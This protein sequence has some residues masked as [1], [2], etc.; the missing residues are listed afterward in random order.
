MRRQSRSAPLGCDASVC[1]TARRQA[2]RGGCCGGRSAH[3]GLTGRK[4]TTAKGLDAGMACMSAGEAYMKAV[5]ILRVWRVRLRAEYPA[6]S[7]SDLRSD[8]CPVQ[9]HP[10]EGDPKASAR[11]DL[12]GDQCLGRRADAS[13]ARKE[14]KKAEVRQGG[15][16]ARCG[17]GGHEGPCPAAQEDGKGQHATRRSQAGR[18]RHVAIRI[19]AA[20]RIGVHKR[21]L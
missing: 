1:G 7:L 14:E 5:R 9:A 21:H 16:K 10:R 4:P 17:Q 12:G 20:A 3:T 2:A 6:V 19:E 15:P 18:S 8:A 13:Q 11:D